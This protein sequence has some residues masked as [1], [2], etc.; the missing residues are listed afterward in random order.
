MLTAL[1]TSSLADEL[2]ENRKQEFFSRQNEGENHDNLK[3]ID[4]QDIEAEGYRHKET[5]PGLEPVSVRTSKAIKFNPYRT[6]NTNPIKSLAKSIFS[7]KKRN[8]QPST[9]NRYAALSNKDSNTNTY[10]SYSTN[11]NSYNSNYGAYNSYAAST[12]NNYNNNNNN[13]NNS[14]N[15][16]NSNNNDNTNTNYN[17]N[18]SD[19]ETETTEESPAETTISSASSTL[20]STY[21][22]TPADNDN[23]NDDDN[24]DERKLLIYGIIA[25]IFFL[26]ICQGISYMAYF[27]AASFIPTYLK[28]GIPGKRSIG[29]DWSQSLDTITRNV[30][31]SINNFKNH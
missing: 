10:S 24:D 29:D 3:S 26:V 1:A 21:G 11:S 6:G 31:N 17:S 22:K 16:Y 27:G 7:S 13:N 4:D 8:H 30:Y 25:Y 2:L 28:P 14:N 15:N 20:S 12:N 5:Q 9:Y 19:D 23:D 18:V